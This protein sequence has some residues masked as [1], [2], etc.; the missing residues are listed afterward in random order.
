MKDQWKG[1]PYEVEHQIMEGVP[2]YLV[3]NPAD[4]NAHESSTEMTFSH[5][6]DTGDSSLYGCAGQAGQ[7]HHHHPREQTQKSET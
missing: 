5:C 3:Q 4:W 2:S 6:S 1:E 7:V